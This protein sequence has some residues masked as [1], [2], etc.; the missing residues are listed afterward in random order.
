MRRGNRPELRSLQRQRLYEIFAPLDP[1]ERLPRELLLEEK[2][3]FRWGLRMG[4]QHVAGLLWMP[5]IALSLGIAT[6]AFGN[7]LIALPAAPPLFVA[8]WLFAFRSAGWRQPI[9]AL[10]TRHAR[11]VTHLLVARFRS[12]GT[13]VLRS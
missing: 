10:S 8:F 5:T 13:H 9:A 1:E 12:T 6:W 2:E 7:P 11:S 3:G 4:R